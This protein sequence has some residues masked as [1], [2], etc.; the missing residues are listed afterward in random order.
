MRKLLII[1][2]LTLIANSVSADSSRPKREYVETQTTAVMAETAVNAACVADAWDD[3]TP[4]CASFVIKVLGRHQAEVYL[5]FV[6]G[7]TATKLHMQCET[8]LTLLKPWAKIQAGDASI[9][10]VVI[11]GN[12]EFWWDVSDFGVGLDDT[13]VFRVSLKLNDFALRCRVWTTGGTAD[14]KATAWITFGAP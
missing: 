3:D 2:G 7:G 8:S 14:D 12:R 9:A 11:M 5:K 6:R 10:P 1:F 13:D 4:T